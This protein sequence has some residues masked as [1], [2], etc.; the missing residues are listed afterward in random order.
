MTVAE[1]LAAYNATPRHKLVSA[2]APYATL[3]KACLAA[4]MPPYPFRVVAWAQEHLKAN[5]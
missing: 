4:G 3:R 2:D 5:P 1:A